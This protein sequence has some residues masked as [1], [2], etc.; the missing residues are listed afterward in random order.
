MYLN[1]ITQLR[2][3]RVVSASFDDTVK[4]WNKENFKCL[5]TLTGHRSFN[6]VIEMIDGRIATGSSDNYLSLWY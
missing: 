1:S 3:G 4:V 5:S 2:D 6:V